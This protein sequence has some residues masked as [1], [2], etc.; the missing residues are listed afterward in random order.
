VTADPAPLPPCPPLL[1]PLLLLLLL[2]EWWNATT[3][4]EYWRLWNMPVHKWMLRHVYFPLI[5]HKVPKF[6]A[7][8]VGGWMGGADG[9]VG[10]W[11]GWVGGWRVIKRPD[12]T[13]HAGGRGAL[14]CLTKR[15]SLLFAS[16]QQDP[17]H[18]P[19]VLCRPP[20]PLPLPAGLMVFFVSAVFHEVLVGVPLHMLRLWSFWGLMAQVRGVGK[21]WVGSR[22][23]GW[24]WA[25]G[26]WL[27]TK[28][29]VAFSWACSG[30]A[31]TACWE[32]LQKFLLVFQPP[33]PST[34]PRPTPP[35][36][37]PQV[38]LMIATEWLKARFRSDRV[39]NI[40]FWVSFCFVGQPLAMILYYHD[41]RQGYTHPFAGLP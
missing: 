36:T 24:V 12:G 8:E 7:G 35:T 1:P 40:I 30:R 31:C 5:R 15:E 4:G 2:Q 27:R 22:V 20:V 41:H 18:Y 17:Q 26:W 39:G 9:W 37:L 10:G 11:R 14:Y 28:L 13:L 6:H 25:S 34:P 3:V 21:L 32:A 38:P 23:V 29:L 19:G 16:C 33:H